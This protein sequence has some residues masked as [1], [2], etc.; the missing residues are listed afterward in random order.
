MVPAGYAATTTEHGIM[1]SGPEGD[2]LLYAVP[3]PVLAP[4]AQVDMVLVDVVEDPSVCGALRRTGVVG[5]STALVGLGGDH[6]V[7][8]PGELERRGRMW[9]VSTVSDNQEL[10]CPPNAWPPP[11]MRGPHRT[12]VLGGA[13][14]GKSA[15]AELR[16]QAEPEV[17]YVATGPV[18][19]VADSSWQYRVAA[20]RERRPQWWHTEETL[21][22]AGV[23]ERATGAVLVDG[24]GSWLAGV[25]DEC[26]VWEAETG[27]GD[28]A[29][30]TTRQATGQA[31]R[32]EAWQRV[33]ELVATWRQTA[34]NVVAVSDEVGS[35]V[36]PPTVS[37]GLFRDWLGR[38]NEMLATESEEAVLTVAGRILEL[39]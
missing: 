13:R 27:L 12:L 15:E 7:S 19:G 11:R 18:P 36:V 5:T 3:H 22:V 34:A 20:H 39:S 28:G 1:V 24:L 9:G 30:E 38:L 2:R 37:G 8:S 10:Q 4:G 14:S 31:A 21:D 23:L 29:G 25:M 33:T 32:Q 17:T 35:G 6:R 16:L 26:G